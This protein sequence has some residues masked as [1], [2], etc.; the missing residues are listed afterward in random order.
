M[1]TMP[2]QSPSL[3]SESCI[4]SRSSVKASAI[5]TGVSTETIYRLIN[6]ADLLTRVVSDRIGHSCLKSSRT[7]WTRLRC[8]R[9]SSGC[10]SPTARWC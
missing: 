9:R 4:G 5:T 1:V 10:R 3:S 6:K 8:R 2:A 7:P